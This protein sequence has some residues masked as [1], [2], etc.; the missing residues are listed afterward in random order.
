MGLCYGLE[1]SHSPQYAH[2]LL[3]IIYS[4]CLQWLF[5][6]PIEIIAGAFTIGYWN[7]DLSKSIFV[8]IFLLA[9]IVINLFG[10]KT[11]GEAEYIFSLIK[12]TAI[13]GFMYVTHAVVNFNANSP[14]SSPS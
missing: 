11:Y 12:I 1:V 6:L 14:A 3:L 4:Y 8:A 13:V 9:I 7:K 2:L 5:I 10:V